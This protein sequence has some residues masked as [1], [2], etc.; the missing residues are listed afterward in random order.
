M[1]TK[2]TEN[3]KTV[4]FSRVKR[5][6]VRFECYHLSRRMRHPSSCSSAPS[7]KETLWGQRTVIGATSE[8][9]GK[10]VIT[11]NATSNTTDN[12]SVFKKKIKDA[13]R[14][15]SSGRLPDLLNFP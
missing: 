14:A 3:S 7:D 1:E 4:L 11:G 5:N 10:V 9:L 12:F 2:L 13:G 15:A 8:Q 6:L